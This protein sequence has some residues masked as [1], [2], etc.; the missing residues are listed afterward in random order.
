MSLIKVF[1][2]IVRCFDTIFHPD[3]PIE[4]DTIAI[5]G[6]KHPTKPSPFWKQSDFPQDFYGNAYYVEYILSPI[7]THFLREK[8]L[9]DL[10]YISFEKFKILQF[11]QKKCK[12]LKKKWF[13][14]GFVWQCLCGVHFISNIYPFSRRKNQLNFGQKIHS[15]ESY[16]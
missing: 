10:L 16:L 2:N 15:G 8:N 12:F 13:H 6:I 1:A 9:L 4:L 3:I 5:Y 11:F 14:P 7:F